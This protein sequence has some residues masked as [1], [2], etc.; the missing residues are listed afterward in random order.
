MAL[1]VLPHLC[2][3]SVGLM[4]KALHVTLLK[5]LLSPLW[6]TRS[7]FIAARGLAASHR[8]LRAFHL[9]YC[10]KQLTF[11]ISTAIKKYKFVLTTRRLEMSF[12]K[13]K[14][15]LANFTNLPRNVTHADGMLGRNKLEFRYFK[16][17]HLH[18]FHKLIANSAELMYWLV[19][20][21]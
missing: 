5:G 19:N 1:N 15:G 17:A 18:F 4:V 9:T 13:K 7:E 20:G 8:H 21:L 3:Y 12:Q 14:K 6:T 11:M 10:W 2:K 16:K